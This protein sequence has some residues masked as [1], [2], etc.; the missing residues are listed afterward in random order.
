MRRATMTFKPFLYS[1]L[2]AGV[3]LFVS[4][5]ADVNVPDARNV[6]IPSPVTAEQRREAINERP[7]SVMYLPL[8][9]DILIPMELAG[10]Q[11]PKD[12]VGPF[13]LR[14]ETLA[15][16]L[17]LIL[18]EYDIALAF[19]TNEGLTRQITVANLSGP[20]DK[21]VARVCSLA[22]LYCSYEDE[23]I[24]VKDTQVFTVSL[25]P[26][27][28]DGETEFINDVIEGLTAIVGEDAAAPVSDA[29]TRSVIYTAT[30]RS[31]KMAEQYFQRLRANTALVVFETYIWE[32]S[33][34]SGNST[35]INWDEFTTFGKFN[36]G[37]SVAGS[38]GANFTNPVS[39]GLPTTNFIGRDTDPV[40]FVRFLSQ[41]GAVKTISQ[42]QISVLS[43]SEADLRVA[44]TQNFVSEITTTLSEGQSTTS[45]TTDSVDTGFTLTIGSSWDKSTVYADVNISLEN[46]NAIEDFTFS[47]GGAAGT[48]T[49]IQLPQ[50]SE[51]ELNTQIRVRPGDSILIA[52]LVRESDNFDS[53]GPGFMEPI[54]PDSRTAETRNL[55]LVFMMRPR[56]I[57][58][59]SGD[60]QRYKN[61]LASKT[62]PTT[63]IESP[64]IGLVSEDVLQPSAPIDPM[65]MISKAPSIDP[66]IAEPITIEPSARPVIEPVA[67][68]EPIEPIIQ[69]MPEPIIMS[70]SSDSYMP[71]VS[72][73]PMS[74]SVSAPLVM[75]AS[76]ESYAAE[77]Q[78]PAA[79]KPRTVEEILAEETYAVA[80]R[81]TAPADIDPVMAAPVYV[82]PVPTVAPVSIVPAEP[83]V[84]SAPPP[85]TVNDILGS[86]P[87]VN[88]NMT[89]DAAPSEA[90]LEPALV[91]NLYVEEPVA[92][93]PIQPSIAVRA[94]SY[95]SGYEERYTPS[96]SS[97]R[98]SRQAPRTSQGDRIVAPSTGYGGYTSYN[99]N[100]AGR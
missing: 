81:L 29:T 51:R 6:S 42:P 59:T 23:A 66:V 50:T 27:G 96:T 16:A 33:L 71:P 11:L 89:E 35:G 32:V 77:T 58:Y 97:A 17:Q 37:I 83:F 39:I 94:N 14:G 12:R 55:E 64:V 73:E 44:D 38:V 52:G 30:Q 46:V 53:R 82:P 76:S 19:E 4:G 75:S 74:A 99:S 98:V 57:V 25:P 100:E 84:T 56:V 28:N 72:R 86:D 49:T 3:S 45:V 92:P 95:S 61:Y 40:E 69:K 1:C 2:V 79:A 87:I 48:S 68:S 21:V 5:C 24:I 9:E 26:I 41:F 63:L 43:G 78:M 34:N 65:P 62:A 10:E 22:D 15:G 60:D 31:S 36:T 8:G 47:D 20:L 18:A 91:P 70:A 13:E 80:P 7:D 93:A 90:M 88:F 67:M 54:L 85:R